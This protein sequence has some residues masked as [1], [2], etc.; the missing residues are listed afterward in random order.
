MSP[1][2]QYDSYLRNRYKAIHLKGK[3]IEHETA[4]ALIEELE[5]DLRQQTKRFLIDLKGLEYI[6]SV[7]IN[8]IVKLVHLINL[9]EGSLVFSN[10]P[11]RITE[12]LELIRLNSVLIICKTENEGEK[13]L[14]NEQIG[15]F[16]A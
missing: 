15:L 14:L 1:L 11:D 16:D 3:F 13:V 2:F 5:Q 4:K 7:G 6:N 10:V 12:L 9:N 8:S